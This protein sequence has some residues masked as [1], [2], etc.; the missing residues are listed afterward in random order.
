MPK[1]RQ[2]LLTLFVAL[3][4]GVLSLS[5]QSSRKVKQLERQRGDLQRK[6][7]KT[8]QEI[9][10]IKRNSQGE[11]ERLKLVK[12]QVAQRKEAINLI[13]QEVEALK[14]QIDSLG[15][16]IATLR[17]REGRLLSQYAQSVRAVYRGE[18]ERQ[19]LSLLLASQTIGELRTRQHFLARYAR[20]TSSLA[21]ELQATRQ[22]IEHTQA[23]VN[24]SHQQKNE[25]L[26]L[27]ERERQALEKE[28]DKRTQAIHQLKGQEKQ[29]QQNLKKQ[30]QEAE[31]LD[32]QIQAQIQAEIAAAEAK[33]RREA[34]LREARER[35]RQEA[36]R[37][38]EQNK[39]RHEAETNQA[40]PRETQEPTQSRDTQATKDDAEASE[41]D[42]RSERKAAIRGGYAMDADERKLSGSF[43][44]NRGRLPM[45]VRGRYD[46]VRRFGTQQHH[47]YKHIT[48]NSSGID[49]RVQGDRGAYAVFEGIITR[50][51]M[52]AGYG[53]SIIIRHG[54]YLTVYANLVSVQVRTG[55][56]VGAGTRL[57]TISSDDSSGRGNTLHF[58]LW[59]ERS[60]QNPELWIRR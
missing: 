19:R 41:V 8:S 49:L 40:E 9:D 23:E 44:S 59:H 42:T 32:A 46:L 56:R 48:I 58:E 12:Q 6:I 27:R 1:I 4:V 17:G 3:A 47:T 36:R 43:A 50:V 26:Q 60:K 51:F 14:G 53:Q 28:E 34:Q 24:R 38:V 54:N 45:P 15:G 21:K 57:G 39:R 52:T 20:A 13:G 18:V 7:E 37:K 10:R 31:R 16:R 11:A 5:G 33:A 29:L 35:R 25:V 2:I 55:Q 30:R 22:D